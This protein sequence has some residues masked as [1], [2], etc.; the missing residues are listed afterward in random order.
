MYERAHRS[1]LLKMSDYE[2]NN[3]SGSFIIILIVLLVIGYFGYKFYQ[4]WKLGERNPFWKGTDIVQV[5][6]QPYYSL[7]DCAPFRVTLLNNKTAKIQI[8]K[9][10]YKYTYKLVCYLGGLNY[11]PDYVFCRSWDNDNN[12]WDFMPV[13]VNYD[14]DIEDKK[15][16]L[17]LE[18]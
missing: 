2:G 10:V 5:C 13:W 11:S 14:D 15:I 12:Q 17:E 16:D 1:Y 4:D 6:K 7:K 9:S 3:N 18:K 8:T